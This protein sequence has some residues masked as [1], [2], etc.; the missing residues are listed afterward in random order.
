MPISSKDDDH[1]HHHGED[2]NHAY[3][4][5][6]DYRDEN[7]H[8]HHYQTHNNVK[9]DENDDYSGTV[10]PIHE[11]VI[12][13]VESTDPV[14]AEAVIADFSPP[15]PQ[16]R[17]L[18]RKIFI[19]IDYP[20]S[21]WFIMIQ[22]L[23]ERFA[24]YGFKTILSLYLLNF[25]GYSE[26]VSTT[27]IHT[28]IFFAYFTPLLGG[29]VADAL[30]G[31]YW[32]ILIFSLIYCAGQI[33]VCVTAI[34]GVTGIPP[35]GWGIGLGLFLV[36]L[37]TGAIKSN[38]STFG[39]DQFREDQEELISSFFAIFYFSI[40]L[41]STVS[42]FV[43]PIIRTEFNYAVA[44][45]VPAVLL[46]IATI[47][48]S[49]G[50]CWYRTTKPT[51]LVKN[52][53]LKFLHVLFVALFRRGGGNDESSPIRRDESVA[54]S[55]GSSPSNNQL[56]FTSE[57]ATTSTTTQQEDEDER[58]WIDRARSRFS[59]KEVYDAKCVWRVC[60][61]LLPI[62]VFWSLFDQHSSRFVYQA[63]MMNRKIGS[64]E[65]GSDQITTLNPILVIGLVIVFDRFVYKGINFFYTLTPLRKIGLGMIIASF[66]FICAG[67]LE[68]F[69]QMYPHKVHVAWQIP[70]YV[71]LS[72]G[73]I[74][75]SV[76]GLAFAYQ[77]SPKE[78]KS[79]MQAYY[80]LTVSVGNVIVVIVASI[81]IEKTPM[82]Q[83]YE[84]LFFALLM[85]GG[86]VFHLVM[87]NM[88]KYRA[89]I[90]VGTKLEN[91]TKE[92][93]ISTATVKYQADQ[94]EA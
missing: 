56:E 23:C 49:I 20:I 4:F 67:I 9:I 24:F 82:K 13:S 66:S 85:L 81:P 72:I 38:V 77:E 11:T 75:V 16:Q 62:T 54:S 39:G 92:K 89:K 79:L 14:K 64:F 7:H 69:V 37:G 32:T 73:E 88:Y 80:L 86:L 52:P 1:H 33:I 3:P 55:L 59:H 44:F 83:V 65:L 22:E 15:S 93:A 43:T 94:T 31:K 36:G 2:S 74:F 63:E 41:G 26:D 47:V 78:M 58:H 10:N 34:E 25:M 48:F 19:F 30:I 29:F 21:T 76:T 5:D 71:F 28:F 17:S 53:I 57:N 91:E 46:I 6:Q 70:Q 42:S 12:P 40:N 50:K 61:T 51:G 27:I 18:L 8:H 60:I 84:F 35:Q 87:A 45:G 90:G 68:V